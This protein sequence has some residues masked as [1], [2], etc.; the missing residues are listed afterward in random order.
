VTSAVA[1]HI[2]W[3]YVGV[4]SLVWRAKRHADLMEMGKYSEAL[5]LLEDI[6]R[7]VAVARIWTRAGL[8]EALKEGACD[9]S[10]REGALP[11]GALPPPEGRSVRS[12]AG[13]TEPLSCN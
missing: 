11:E 9:H 8:D 10:Q 5:E 4:S 12:G 1:D 7:E 3:A 13:G 6:Q 2:S